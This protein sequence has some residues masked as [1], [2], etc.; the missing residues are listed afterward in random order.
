MSDERLIKRAADTVLMSL[1]KTT[2]FILLGAVLSI[3]AA[4]GSHSIAS[5]A[6]QQSANMTNSTSSAAGTGASIVP[7]ASTL[8]DK[9]FSPNPIIAK[10]GDNVTWTN[11]DSTFHTITSG[12]G[13]SDPNKGKEF[14]SSPGLK[15]FL[16]P[17]QSFSHKFMTAGQFPY[18]CQIHPTMVGKVT[19]K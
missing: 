8:A 3:G 7:N 13:A 6:A 17:N 1:Q 19:V 16:Q 4:L 11:K 2:A 9:A 10:V 12:T 5:I 18:F 15:T 14:D